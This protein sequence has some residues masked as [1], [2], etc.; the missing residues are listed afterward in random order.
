MDNLNEL[1]GNLNALR[2]VVFADATAKGFHNGEPIIGNYTAN[3]HSEV[4]ELWEAYRLGKL[5]SPC[6]KSEKMLEIVGE[7]LTCAEEEL[8]DIL[9]RTLDFCAAFGI[10]I[11]KAVKYKILFNRTRSFRNGGKLA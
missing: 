8:A 6:D 2:D 11:N 10:D 3:L 5:N 1:V 4:S 9:I 7:T